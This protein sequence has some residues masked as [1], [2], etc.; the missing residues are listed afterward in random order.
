MLAE[1]NAPLAEHE[2]R[3]IF[4]QVLGSLHFMHMNRVA[5]RNLKLE[6][7]LMRDDGR[8]LLTDYSYAAILSKDNLFDVFYATSLPYMAPE[9][10]TR[11]PYDPL[12]SDIW[13]YGVCTFIALNNCIPYDV[14]RNALSCPSKTTSKSQSEPKWRAE[15]ES[16]LSEEAKGCIRACL[17]MDVNMRTNTQALLQH[18]WFKGPGRETSGRVGGGT[19]NSSTNASGGGGGTT[20]YST[21]TSRNN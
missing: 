7:I 3:P 5:H 11:I 6:N 9:I 1:R 2:V 15:L 14:E 21:A 13:S 18:P 4:E 17:Q 20:S 10:V 12:T 16:S 19:G 8:P